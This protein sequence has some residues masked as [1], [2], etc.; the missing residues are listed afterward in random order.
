MET[1]RGDGAGGRF[2]LVVAL[3]SLPSVSCPRNQQPHDLDR[4]PQVASSMSQSHLPSLRLRHVHVPWGGPVPLDVA[5]VGPEPGDGAFEVPGPRRVPARPR[6][7]PSDGPEGLPARVLGPDGISRSL[8][9][10]S[11]A[12]LAF[13]ALP[14]PPLSLGARSNGGIWSLDRDALRHI[15]SSGDLVASVKVS[16]VRLA[17]ATADATWVVGLDEATL[18]GGDGHV[19]RVVPWKDP[20]GTIGSKGGLCRLQGGEPAEIRCVDAG[21]AT[22]ARPLPTA[23]YFER[24]LAVEQDATWTVTVTTLRRHGSGGIVT[25]LPVLGAGIATAGEPF[26]A[27]MDGDAT[28]LWV[29]RAASRRLA[30]EPSSHAVLAVDGERAL[31]WAGSRAA[32]YRGQELERAIEVDEALF[33]DEVFPMAWIME[34]V[35]PFVAGRDGTIL[36]PTSGPSGMAIVELTF[37]A[38]PKP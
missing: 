4:I 34:S 18:V 9:I 13:V 17:G 16:G 30:L 14:A 37:A 19:E 25:E 2:V 24:L 32:W 22:T 15:S 38:F 12:P 1:R 7:D 28:V 27:G 11:F 10:R 23:G 35:F 31:V 33:R 36:I 8:A 5:I 29:G 3:L 6:L 21:G 20:L 26:V